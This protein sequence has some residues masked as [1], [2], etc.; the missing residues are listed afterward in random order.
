MWDSPGCVA[1]AVF[2]LSGFTPDALQ[3]ADDAG[4][5]LLSNG[6]QG[7]PTPENRSPR[8]VEFDGSPDRVAA[9]AREPAENLW[10]PSA[11]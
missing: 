1:A 5:A 10:R 8:R 7:V 11:H 6:L 4:A 2:S 9:E 3:W